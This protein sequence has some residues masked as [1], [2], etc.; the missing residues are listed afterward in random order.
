MKEFNAQTGGRYTYV[1]DIV[2]LQDLA[3][4]F[5][6]IFDDCDNFIIS[7]CKISGSTISSG[8]VYINGKI[9][10]FS[11]VSGIAAWP[12][13]LYETNKTETVAY[14]SGDD[15][16]GRNIYGCAISSEVPTSLDALTGETPMF[17]QLTEAGGMRLRDAFFGKYALLLHSASE[18]QTVSDV[19]TFDKDINVN[20]VLTANGA[21]SLIKGNAK[22][23]V[24]YSDNKLVIQ[25]QVTG[26]TMNIVV[27]AN[28]GFKLS[29]NNDTLLTVNPNRTTITPP[30]ATK[31]ST[32]GNIYI[33]QNDIVNKDVA[34]DDAYI[35][36]NVK[37]YNNDITYYRNTIIGDGKGSAV[38]KVTGS[39]KN[40]HIKGDLSI[41][42][43]ATASLSLK[44]NKLIQW[45]NETDTQIAYVGYN[46][47]NVFGIKNTVAS[48]VI[49]AKEFV[50]ITPAIKEN[51][52][53]YQKNMLHALIWWL[54]SARKLMLIM[55]TIK[56]YVIQ[57]SL[58]RT[59]D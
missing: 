19:V 12:Q 48:I 7:G 41:D 39:T 47:G 28:E 11:G 38:L 5:A 59:R 54:N 22:G 55:F 18:T 49:S 29:I 6:S 44:K 56:H 8:Y 33:A 16:V 24:F 21:I 3:L 26:K 4:A 57:N 46:E 30:I 58:S 36:I 43:T 13:Y 45:L 40:V 51:G 37:G 20:G 34:S 35:N 17:I 32:I 10:H 15:K 31:T 14:A 53:Y 42:S 25:S 2:N 9:R 1:D 27:D 23:K 52:T 50:N